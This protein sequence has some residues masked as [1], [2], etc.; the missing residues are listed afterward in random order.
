QLIDLAV[1]RRAAAP[2]Q[3]RL[4][5]GEGSLD[6][7][8][9]VIRGVDAEGFL[10]RV[11]TDRGGA[12]AIGVRDRRVGGIAG[13]EGEQL[14]AGIE[15]DAVVARLRRLEAAVRTT[16]VRDAGAPRRDRRAFANRLARGREARHLGDSLD[17]GAVDEADGR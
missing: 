14:P 15:P 10:D 7:L 9:F 1:A 6:D 13:A 17:V 4:A 16:G 8:E 12:S 2:R 3:L 11:E 5:G